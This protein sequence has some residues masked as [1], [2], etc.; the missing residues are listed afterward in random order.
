MAKNNNAVNNFVSISRGNSKMG[1]IPSVSLP[2]VV[3]CP[4]G[5]PCNKKCYAC[6]ICRLR[7]TVR[8][9]YDRNLEILS[10]DPEAYWLDVRRA[11]KMSAYFRFHV[12]GDIPHYDYLLHMVETAKNAPHCQIL[13][14]TKRYEWI[15]MFINENGALPENLH[16]IFSEWGDSWTVPNP[17]KLPTSRVIFKGEAVP[18]G[19][20]VCG[21]NCYECACRGVGCWELKSGETIAFFEH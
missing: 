10:T 14:F 17:H 15:N 18:D 3:T 7:A 16:M 6:K 1:A 13:C 11:V 21:G 4:A 9:A 19:V 8:A 5:V 20:K 2:P 12:S